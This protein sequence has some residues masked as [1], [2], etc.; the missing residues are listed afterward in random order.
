[1]AGGAAYS[2]VSVRQFRGWLKNGLRYVQLPN[3]RI[4]VKFSWIDE[5]LQKF[6]LKKE[7]VAESIAENLLEGWD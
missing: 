6:E 4:L 2:D 3:K 5:F 7:S 1:M